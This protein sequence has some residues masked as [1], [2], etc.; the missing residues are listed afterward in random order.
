MNEITR[1]TGCSMNASPI[2]AT[3]VITTFRSP[4]GSPASSKIFAIRVPCGYRGV[5]VGLDDDRVAEREGRCDGLHRHQEREVERA[6]HTDDADGQP[7]EAVLPAVRQGGQ[8]TAGRTQRLTD[9][10][11][12]EFLGGP[13]LVLRLDPGAAEFVD[14]R[15]DDVV[16]QFP[17]DA[18][19]AFQDFA[20][21]VRSGGGPG[22]LGALGGAV[23]QVDLLRGGNGDR[24]EFLPVEGIEIDDVP[25]AGSGPPLTVDVLVGQLVEEGHADPLTQVQ[26]PSNRHR[27]DES[28]E[29]E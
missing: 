24:G 27:T 17:G 15:V 1:G 20:A 9:R 28:G 25:R 2:S 12:Q 26:L 21:L 19:R 10:V 18:Q 22:A 8:E 13:D 23:G 11:T 14:D 4:A 3:S 6:D 5:L 29:L 16:V 7:V